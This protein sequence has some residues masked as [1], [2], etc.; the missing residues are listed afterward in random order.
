MEK[1]KEYVPV[2]STRLKLVYD[3][4][5]TPKGLDIANLVKIYENYNVVFWDSS[6]E[7]TKPALYGV[8]GKASLMVVDTKGQELDLEYYSKEFAEK[9][10]WDKELHR[11]KNSPVYYFSN[12]LTKVWPHRNEDL[13]NYLISIGLKTI[14]SKDSEEAAKLWEDQKVLIQKSL[15]HITVEDLKDLSSYIEILQVEY[16]ARVKKLEAVL[17]SKVRLVDS[18]NIALESKKACGNLIEK[19]KK[20]LPVDK[21][22]SDKY[23]TSKGKWDISMLA[24]TSYDQL[25]NMLYEILRD[26]GEIQE[27]VDGPAGEL[28]GAVVDVAPGTPVVGS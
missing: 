27:Q 2:E 20:H 9:E 10:F 28:G 7:G 18:N 3:V 23:R 25:L 21:R 4:T 15:A 5:S 13:Q 12:Y 6:K 17:E 24:V 11:C 1:S 22:Y 19:I 14:E 16:N 26:K 8:D